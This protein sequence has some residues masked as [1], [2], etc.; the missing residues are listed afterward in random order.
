MRSSWLPGHPAPFPTPLCRCCANIK[1][2]TIS[3]SAGTSF[4][5][6]GGGETLYAASGNLN[7]EVAAAAKQSDYLIVTNPGRLFV[8]LR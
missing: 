1:W 3:G 6:N 7:S 4:N 5:Y 2:T 8:A